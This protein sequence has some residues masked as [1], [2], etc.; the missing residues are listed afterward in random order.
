LK[1]LTVRQPWASLIVAGIKDVE[2]R[3]WSTKYRG[4]LGIHA[5][6]RVETDALEQ[7]GYLLGDRPL[8]QGALI[9]S[10]TVID[11]IQNSKSEW[12]TPGAWHWILADA[13]CLVHPRRMDGRLGLWST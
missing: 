10:V 7:F 12:A 9:G 11:C 3:S 13:H 1:I 8:P 2:N 5:G 6:M 4:K